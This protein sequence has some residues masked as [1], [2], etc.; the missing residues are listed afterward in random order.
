MGV[1]GGRGEAIF[2]DGFLFSVGTEACSVGEL[3]DIAYEVEI[4]DLVN[5][6]GDGDLVNWGIYTSLLACDGSGSLEDSTSLCLL[7][8]SWKPV[9]GGFQTNILDA[10]DNQTAT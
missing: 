2:G 4:D 3:G 8:A 9:H 1:A 6:G 10:H 5:C 7:S